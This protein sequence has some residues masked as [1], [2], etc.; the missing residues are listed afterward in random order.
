VACTVPLPPN[1]TRDRARKY[2][3]GVNFDLRFMDMAAF[4]APQG[5]MLKAGTRRDS[6][7]DRH[8][9]L[10]SRTAR[11]IPYSGPILINVRQRTFV[12]QYLAEVAVLNPRAAQL[13][14]I[15]VHRAFARIVSH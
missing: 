3:L 13:A 14:P 2:S 12:C 10:A 4:G 1:P 8:A 9:G 6:A 15:A 11:T 7:L 5:P